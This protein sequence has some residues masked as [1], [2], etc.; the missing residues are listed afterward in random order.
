MKTKSVEESLK[1]V[2]ILILTGIIDLFHRLIN[3]MWY[4]GRHYQVSGHRGCKTKPGVTHVA[5]MIQ[6]KTVLFTY[7]Y[8]ARQDVSMNAEYLCMHVGFVG[9]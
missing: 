1:N 4:F 8:T 5:S 7:S 3:M 9:N 2:H 6:M